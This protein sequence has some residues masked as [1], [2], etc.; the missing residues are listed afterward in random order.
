M[1]GW[2]A[3]GAALSVG[4]CHPREPMRPVGTSTP[5]PTP[6]HGGP[7]TAFAVASPV[8][9]DFRTDL[10]KVNRDRFISNGHAGGRFEANVYVTPTAK[11]AAFSFLGKVQTGT[12]IV[13]EEIE[14]GKGDRS[15]PLLMMEKMAPGFAEAHGDWRY[16]V[17]DG[18]AV[19]VGAFD[20]CVKCHDEAPNDHVFRIPDPS[21]DE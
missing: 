17:V 13:M 3:I 6:R 11:D 15:G 18:K 9:Q 1:R 7:D 20:S 4:A 16:A 8:P 19:T 14:R 5:V 2:L 21:G 10:A 12:L